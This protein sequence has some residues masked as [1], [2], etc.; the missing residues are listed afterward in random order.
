MAVMAPLPSASICTVPCVREGGG[1]GHHACGAAGPAEPRPFAPRSR[2]H[3]HPVDIR[4][5][6][7]GILGGCGGRAVSEL[8]LRPRRLLQS[9][10]ATG[11]QPYRAFEGGQGEAAERACQCGGGAACFGVENWPCCEGLGKSTG[12]FPAEFFRPGIIMA[13]LAA[14]T[15]D[16]SRAASSPT[17]SSLD[18]PSS[19]RC[20]APGAWMVGTVVRKGRS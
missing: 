16:M 15:W 14:R 8:I 17:G 1:G 18:V 2:A 4:P 10:A 3:I 5:R 6:S 19:S 13:A 7:A 20:D 9:R 12:I 11:A